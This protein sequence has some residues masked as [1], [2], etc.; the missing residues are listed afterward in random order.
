MKEITLKRQLLYIMLLA[1]LIVIAYIWLNK[2]SGGLSS[3]QAIGAISLITPMFAV[4]LG[5]MYKD[6]AKTKL[7]N[8]VGR[9]G[10]VPKSFRNLT[11]V[12]ILVYIVAIITVV[13]LKAFSTTFSYNQFQTMLTAV[14]SGF[15][16]YVG[17]IIFSLFKKGDDD[18]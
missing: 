18:E 16:V 1:K 12:T 8:S 10:S 7:K 15:G 13:T 11:F 6:L 14:E 17:Q 9:P 3:E 4:Y 2:N 5:V